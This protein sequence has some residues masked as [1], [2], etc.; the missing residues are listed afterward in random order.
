VVDLKTFAFFAIVDSFQRGTRTVFGWDGGKSVVTLF[1]WN[2]GIDVT[3][4]ITH[5]AVT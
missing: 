2:N 1:V 5:V 4:E 3:I